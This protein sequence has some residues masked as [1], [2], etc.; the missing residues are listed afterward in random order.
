MSGCGSDRTSG[1][2]AAWPASHA[3]TRLPRA[4]RS[5]GHLGIDGSPVSL[6]FRRPTAR[7]VRAV[8]PG[9]PQGR[10]TRR[11]P[12]CCG[13][14]AAPNPLPTGQGASAAHPERRVQPVLAHERGA[15]VTW[16]KESR[17]TLPA[18]QGEVSG[19]WRP[20]DRPR[21]GRLRPSAR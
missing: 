17:R 14:R 4:V 15:P 12:L 3:R 16:E 20:A 8:G 13:A 9:S 19:W 10:G 6:P 2:E 21:A 7:R 11:A 18:R 1:S 5:D